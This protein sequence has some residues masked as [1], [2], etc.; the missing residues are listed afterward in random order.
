VDRSEAVQGPKG[1][2]A[3]PIDRDIQR[4]LATEGLQV[5]DQSQELELDRRDRVVVRAQWIWF[6]FDET[7]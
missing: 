1:Q 2:V 6:L 7:G 3:G 4:A 5:A